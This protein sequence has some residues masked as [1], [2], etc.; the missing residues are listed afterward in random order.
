MGHFKF[1]AAFCLS[2]LA[3]SAAKAD[4]IWDLDS[5]AGVTADG[6]FTTGNS[7]LQSFTASVG[8]SIAFNDVQVQMVSSDTFENPAFTGLSPAGWAQTFDN[9]SVAVAT[10]SPAVTSVSFTLNWNDRVPAN[11]YST[12]NPLVFDIFMLRGTTVRGAF[13]W[14]YDGAAHGW[15]ES[16]LVNADVVG[17]PMP[18]AN[19]MGLSLMGITGL[20][21]SRRKAKAVA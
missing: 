20:W 6:D 5:T 9:G 16:P 1:L 2:A 11:S 17:T 7:K 21:Q 19:W 15:T 12:A 18:A 4:V 13:E 3:L 8:S 14:S 10:G